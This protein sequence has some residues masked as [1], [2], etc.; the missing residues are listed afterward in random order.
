MTSEYFGPAHGQPRHV[1]RPV[2]TPRRF[3]RGPIQ[4][5]FTA[6][7]VPIM[8]G[9]KP[10]GKTR[11]WAA[12]GLMFVV[13]FFAAAPASLATPSHPHDDHHITASGVP[14]NLVGVDHE[15]IAPAAIP[16]APDALADALVPRTRTVLM[17]LGLILAVALLGG[18]ALRQRILVGRD[19][20]RTFVLV[21]PGR[22]VLARHCISRR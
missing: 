10:P 7:V 14:D 5:H 15:H 21:S 6:K 19:P 9:I 16:G 1:Q 11:V 13:A 8:S 2:T 22:D 20:P 3:G 18:L 12:I 17:A 4:R